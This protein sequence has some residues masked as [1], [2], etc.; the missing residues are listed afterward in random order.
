MHIFLFTD[1]AS[2]WNPW[3]SWWWFIAYNEDKKVLFTWKKYFWIR[4]NNQSEYLALIEWLKGSVKYWAKEISILMDSELII[5]QIN[6]R[7]RVKNEDLKPFFA[8]VKQILKNVKW[9]ANHVA[10]DL[11]KAADKLSN[12]AIDDLF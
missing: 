6:G 4:T 10:R 11:N 3:K 2:R 9:T 12:E 1:W 7:Y 5:R 8:E